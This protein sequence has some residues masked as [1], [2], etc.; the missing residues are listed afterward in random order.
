M[1]NEEFIRQAVCVPAHEIESA[2]MESR[3]LFKLG[4]TRLVFITG[5]EN[6]AQQWLAS[7]SEE[8]RLSVLVSP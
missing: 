8:E 6:L 5:Q 3:R 7:G 1:K 2:Y 4:V